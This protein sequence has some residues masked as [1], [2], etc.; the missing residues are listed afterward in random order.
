MYARTQSS[1]TRAQGPGS[2]VLAAI[3]LLAVLSAAPVRASDSLR[4]GSRLVSTDAIAP[5]VL[6]ACG[7]P[8]LRDVWNRYADAYAGQVGD[9]EV[10]TYNFGPNQLLRLLHFRNGRLHHIDTEGYGFRPVEHPQ[11][12]PNDILV[13]YSKYRLLA[14]CGEPVQRRALGFLVPYEARDRGRLHGDPLQFHGFTPNYQEEWTYN[15]GSGYLL[16]RI[17]LENGKVTS[18]TDGDRG[19]ELP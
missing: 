19:Y 12:S 18:I 17:V 4:C 1:L 15:F 3:L 2:A 13:G 5:A 11:C 6:A 7:E 16:R 10:W 9:S 8:A 14:Y